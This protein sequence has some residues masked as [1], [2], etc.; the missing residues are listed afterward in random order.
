MKID[1]KGAIFLQDMTMPGHDLQ[2]PYLGYTTMLMR[3]YCIAVTGIRDFNNSAHI[4]IC[5]CGNPCG[6]SPWGR[7]CI[8]EEKESSW[9]CDICKAREGRV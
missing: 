3:C 2:S 5:E 4:I 9:I 6:A 7:C 1:V 8:C